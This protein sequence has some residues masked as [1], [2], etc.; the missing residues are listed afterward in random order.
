M[1]QRLDRDIETDDGSRSDG[2]AM[3]EL[4]T[5]ELFGIRQ[6]LRTRYQL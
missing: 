1:E 3:S 6:K 2:G 5:A 4:D